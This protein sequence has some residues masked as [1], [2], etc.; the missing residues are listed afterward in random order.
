MPNASELFPSLVDLTLETQLV[1]ESMHQ[2]HAAET[3]ADNEDIALEIILI[4]IPRSSGVGV[5][6]SDVRT[7]VN[8]DGAVNERTMEITDTEEKEQDDLLKKYPRGQVGGF[9]TCTVDP[10]INTYL[11]R[12]SSCGLRLKQSQGQY[13]EPW[14]PSVRPTRSGTCPSTLRGRFRSGCAVVTVLESK[15]DSRAS[16]STTR[17]RE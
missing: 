14:D 17:M 11:P 15:S 13:V 9:L 7:H 3:R 5:S 8:H 10:K 2:V 1:A 4:G 16:S 6:S 12:T